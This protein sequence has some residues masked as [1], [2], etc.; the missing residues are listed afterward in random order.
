MTGE[1]LPAEQKYSKEQ[2]DL[3]KNLFAKGCSEDELALFV[4]L[5]RTY[6]LDPFKNQIWCVKYGS[7]QARVFTGRDGFL[8]IAHRSG[9]FDGMESG[10]KEEAGRTLG[11]AQVHRKDMTHPFYVEVDLAEYKREYGPNVPKEH[12][13]WETKPRTMIQKVAESQALRKAFSASGLYSPEEFGE[14]E[15]KPEMKN[16]TPDKP[17]AAIQEP[18]AQP[19]IID[20]DKPPEKKKRQVKVGG[21]WMDEDKADLIR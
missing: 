2:L 16:V 12:R 19:P 5:A 15:K 13:I 10:V 18:K 14:E 20:A 7:G 4:T 11:W 8:E 1:T 3:I 6:Q 21:K 17:Q 9:Q